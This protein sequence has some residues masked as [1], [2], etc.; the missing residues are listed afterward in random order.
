MAELRDGAEAFRLGHTD[1]AIPITGV[2]E[3]SLLAQTFNQMTSQL[4]KSQQELEQRVA[5]RTRDLERRTA[6]MEA[7]SEV[8]RA[9]GSLMEIGQLLQQVV[10]LIRLH[11]DLYYVGLFL[12]DETGQWAVLQAGTGQAGRAMRERGHRIR[13]GEGMIGWSVAYSRARVAAEASDD[14]LRLTT[15]E[16]PDTRSEAALPLRSRGRV[17]GALTV[18]S[19]EAGVFDDIAISTLQAM[20]DHVAVALDNSRLYAESQAALESSRRAFGELSQQAWVD[21][22]KTRTDWGYRY[23]RHVVEPAQGAWR[24]EMRQAAQARQTILENSEPASGEDGAAQPAL[25]IPVMVREQV[26]GVL[27]FRKE[28]NSPD[29]TSEEIALL[30][31]LA[32]Q[33]GPALEGAQLYLETQNRAARERLTGQ[34]AARMR[35]TLDLEIVLQTA[36]QEM[37]AVLGLA[38]AEVRLGSAPALD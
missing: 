15:P 33:L 27:G 5:W 10:D 1:V 13:V 3:L 6:Y 32:A 12:I 22:L 28:E 30:E 38:E 21:L 17:I 29:W 24:T 7:S 11:F 14:A 19:D 31:T 4:S 25:A 34:I 20:A 16:L 8:T 23:D 35:E 18:Q 2:D 37:R 36:A 9:V 26:V